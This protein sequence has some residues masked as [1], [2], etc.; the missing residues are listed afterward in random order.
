MKHWKR[1]WIITTPDTF[2]SLLVA[3][4]SLLRHQGPQLLLIFWPEHL[5]PGLRIQLSSNCIQIRFF[6]FV[7]SKLVTWTNPSVHFCKNLQIQ[8]IST[9]RKK[10]WIRNKGSIRHWNQHK[11]VHL[12]KLFSSITNLGVCLQDIGLPFS[13]AYCQHLTRTCSFFLFK[14]M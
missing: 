11:K 8:N 7:L 12:T 13:S 5:Q 2:A 3:G 4:P 9:N 10:I 1:T 6:I 14:S